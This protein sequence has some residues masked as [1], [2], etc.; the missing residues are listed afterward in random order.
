MLDALGAQWPVQKSSKPVHTK[1]LERIKEAERRLLRVRHAPVSLVLKYDLISVGCL[2]LIDYIGHPR[3]TTV[4][5]LVS[6]VKRALAQPYAA[7][8]ILYNMLVKTSVDPNIRWLLASLRLWYL[9]LKQEPTPAE[10]DVLSHNS[11]GRLG[12]S[13][14]E[15]RKREILIEGRG[16]SVGGALLPTHQPWYLCRVIL[17]KHL[18]QLEFQKVARR[19]PNCFGGLLNV[20]EKTHRKYL[21]TLPEY[22]QGVLIRVWT[23]SS[24]DQRE[25]TQNRQRKC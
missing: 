23:G 19:R 14:R 10:V 16:I 9:V 2:S 25:S 1:E 4:G 20:N 8:E 21:A 6:A 12:L 22:K 11:R 5:P 17:V 7:P 3:I 24:Y 13:A 18:K 15:L